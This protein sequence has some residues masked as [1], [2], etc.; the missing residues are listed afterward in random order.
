MRV[1]EM[2]KHTFIFI[3]AVNVHVYVKQPNFH[4]IHRAT[5]A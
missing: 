3:S 1:D 4:R 5:Q 2:F